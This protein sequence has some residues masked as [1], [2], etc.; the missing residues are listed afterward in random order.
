M[1]TQIISDWYS[2]V[3]GATP[4]GLN[5]PR[6]DSRWGEIFRTCPDRLREPPRLL[7]YNKYRVSSPLVKGPGR[8]VDHPP[9]S[10][11]EVKERVE[12]YLVYLSVPSWQVIGRNLPFPWDQFQSAECFNSSPA[13]LVSL[14]LLHLSLIKLSDRFQFTTNLW[15]SGH[16]DIHQDISGGRWANARTQTSKKNNQHTST[17]R[18]EFKPTIPVFGHPKKAKLLST[19]SQLRPCLTSSIL[20]IRNQNT[21]KQQ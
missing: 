9:P 13:T 7:L 19:W 8:G 20:V 14:H 1:L 11:V 17:L 21:L 15:H 3:G 4:Y 10:S 5:C 12:V 2:S 18:A 16:A 6:I